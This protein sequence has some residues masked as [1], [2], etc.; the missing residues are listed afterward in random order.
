MGVGLEGL[1]NLNV[2]KKGTLTVCV[3]IIVLCTLL[4]SSSNFSMSV[5]SVCERWQTAALDMQHE[6]HDLFTGDLVV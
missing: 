2:N 1:N 4:L 6:A 5:E 3:L